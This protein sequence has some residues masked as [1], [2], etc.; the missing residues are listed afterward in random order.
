MVLA[1]ANNFIA[2][3]I[4]DLKVVAIYSSLLPYDEF[5]TDFH[6]SVIVFTTPLK[7]YFSF[8]RKKVG[9]LIQLRI[10]NYEFRAKTNFLTFSLFK[11]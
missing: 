5:L 6:N 2:F 8:G 1:K 10:P 11:N 3:I 4:H 7:K 9:F